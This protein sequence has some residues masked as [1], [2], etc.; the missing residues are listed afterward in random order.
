MIRR[1]MISKGAAATSVRGRRIFSK[2]PV[3]VLKL[4]GLFGIISI[5]STETDTE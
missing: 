2:I 4:F 3:L 5:A 1:I